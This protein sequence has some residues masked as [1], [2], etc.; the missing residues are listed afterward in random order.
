MDVFYHG[1]LAT[2]I[3]INGIDSLK[4]NSE[5][6]ELSLV[7]LGCQMKKT[8]QYTIFLNYNFNISN[9][10][11]HTDSFKILKDDNSIVNNVR[12]MHR[13]K[14]QTSRK[15][16]QIEQNIYPIEADEIVFIAFDIYNIL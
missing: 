14:K 6:G 4:L 7:A 1:D 13:S 15:T 11:L 5:C 2:P 12:F 16:K 9:G 8:S 10:V 3:K